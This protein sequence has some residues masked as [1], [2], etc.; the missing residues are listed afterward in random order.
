LNSE[1]IILIGANSGIGLE[2]VASLAQTSADYHILLCARSLQKGNSALDDIKSIHG[3]S[4]KSTISVLELDVT[5]QD[6]ILAARDEVENTYGKLDILINNAAILI[7][8]P[9]GKLELL[10]ATFE[11]NLFGPWLLTEAFEPL[12]RKSESPLII[13]VSSE[14]GSTTLK[15][16]PTYAGAAVPGDHYRSSKAALNMMTA[17]HRYWFKE[18]GCRVCAFN[19][20]F[21]VTNLTGEKGREMRIAHGARPAK[22]AADALVDVILGKRDS[23]FEKN[24][25]LDLDGGVLPW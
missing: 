3:D 16:D 9:M 10:R 19:P 17:C 25:M 2:T 14:Q 15:L 11:T 20:G 18:W 23:D 13:N 5:I 6:S 24:G 8:Q 21:C 12:L 1:L 22:D 7:V 4:V